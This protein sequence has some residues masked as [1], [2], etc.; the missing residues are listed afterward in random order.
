M[1]LWYFFYFFFTVVR[2]KSRV[3]TGKITK[4]K[5]T[6]SQAPA[7]EISYVNK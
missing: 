3:K 4:E 5:T 2:K 6:Q 1:G 7:I